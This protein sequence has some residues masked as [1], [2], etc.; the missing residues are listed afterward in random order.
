MPQKLV[1]SIEEAVGTS[2]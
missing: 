1:C 2:L